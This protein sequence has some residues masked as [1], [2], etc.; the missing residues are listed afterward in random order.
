VF[1]S[2]AAEQ[3]VVS[4]VATVDLMID[5]QDKRCIAPAF[6]FDQAFDKPEDD[7][8]TCTIAIGEPI[9]D[10]EGFVPAPELLEDDRFGVRNLVDSAIRLGQRLHVIECALP[11]LGPNGLSDSNHR[12]A[13]SVRG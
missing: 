2:D 6:H 11:V 10:F 3:D 4:G 12:L 7:G 9:E 1:G 8:G 13:N 5:V